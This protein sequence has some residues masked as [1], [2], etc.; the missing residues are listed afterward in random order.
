MAVYY[1]ESTS[2]DPWYNLAVEKE[3]SERVFSGDVILY[4]W[5]NQNTVVI[6]RNQNAIKECNTSRLEAEGGYLARRTTGGGAVFHDLGNLNF[7][8]LAAPKLYDLDRQMGVIGNALLKFGIETVRS[9][10]ND[11]VTKN[12]EKFSG[13][14]FSKTANVSIQHGTLMLSVDKDKLSRY[15]TPSKE[16]MQAKGVNSV[17]SRVCNLKDLNPSITVEGMKA[18]LLEAFAHEYGNYETLTERD[19]S[20]DHVQKTKEMFASWEW[21]Y[22]KSPK[23]AYEYGKKFPWGEIQI[24]LTLKGLVISE[25]YV[26]TDALEVELPGQLKTL[27][28]GKRYDFSDVN[29]ENIDSTNPGILDDIITWL[30]GVEQ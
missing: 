29:A 27:L 30:K 4:L 11:I 21:R 7:T 16:K 5:Q 14:A 15:L 3:L 18:A 23:C 6:G 25:C 17:R 24:H 9:G 2:Y 28:L 26:Y 19:L 20:V 12:N 22:G 13:N 1:Y 10:R 8:F